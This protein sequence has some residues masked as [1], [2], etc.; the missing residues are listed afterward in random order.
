[1]SI[2]SVDTEGVISVPNRGK[3]ERGVGLERRGTVGSRGQEGAIGPKLLFIGLMFSLVGTI[4]LGSFSCCV[5]SGELFW[6]SWGRRGDDQS[7]QETR[8][9]S[10]F[11]GLGDHG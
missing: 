1:V 9:L 5:A 8:F 10:S 7:S 6:L 3:M 2:G 4:W 11:V